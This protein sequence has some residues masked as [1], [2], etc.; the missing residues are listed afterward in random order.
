[1]NKDKDENKLDIKKTDDSKLK[2]TSDKIESESSKNSENEETAK[3]KFIKFIKSLIPTFAIGFGSFILVFLLHYLGAFVTLELKL[4]DF[5]FKL[6]GPLSGNDSNSALPQPEGF[7]DLFE[8]YDDVNNNGT[9]DDAEPFRDD[10]GNGRYDFKEMSS[11]LGRSK[12]VQ[13]KLTNKNEYK[14]STR[15]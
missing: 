2:S 1:M 10:N 12:S 5:R 9:W 15:F 13:N 6:R 3:S 8:P 11:N 14:L 7:I 4:Y